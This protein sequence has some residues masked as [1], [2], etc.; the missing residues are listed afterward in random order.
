MSVLVN[1]ELCVECGAYVIKLLERQQADPI[2]RVKLLAVAEFLD[3]CPSCQRWAPAVRA[4]VRRSGN[5][6]GWAWVQPT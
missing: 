5:P 1:A 3:N 6:E 4:L 2:E